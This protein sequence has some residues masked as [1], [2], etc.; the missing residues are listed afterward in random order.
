MQ[1]RSPERAPLPDRSGRVSAAAGRPLRPSP[2]GA[3]RPAP[4]L[5]AL[6]ADRRADRGVL[7]A[8]SGLGVS[9][10]PETGRLRVGPKCPA[11]APSGVHDHARRAGAP[12]S[13]PR[14]ER[15]VQPGAPGPERALGRRTRVGDRG[16]VS[17]P[18]AATEPGD[19]RG[20]RLPTVEL[21]GRRRTTPPGGAGGADHRVG[22]VPLARGSP[23][24]PLPSLGGGD[25]CQLRRSEPTG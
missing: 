16:R 14:A 17:P 22:P 5:R 25:P 21:S 10:P 8:G 7:A 18:T 2:D 9:V 24:C 13:D 4:W 11:R 23:H 1:G 19:A 15:T 6:G 3:G 20:A 12:P